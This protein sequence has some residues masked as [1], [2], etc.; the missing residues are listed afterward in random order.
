MKRRMWLIF[1]L[2]LCLPGVLLGQETETLLW[3]P[4][5]ANDLAG[6]RLYIGFE[7]I[8]DDKG[9]AVLIAT[10]EKGT[11]IAEVDFILPLLGARVYFRVLAFNTS[12]DESEFSNEVFR[13]FPPLNGDD[14][15][16]KFLQE[17]VEFLQKFL[18]EQEQ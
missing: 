7:P 6:Y 9:N 5:V 11:E 17:K 8:P 18:Q 14:L 4:P 10:T 1:L 13:H 2:V 16:L 3:N 15:L 12:G